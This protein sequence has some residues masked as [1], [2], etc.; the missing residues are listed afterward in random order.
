M[1]FPHAR[2]SV[3]YRGLRLV[4]LAA[5]AIT[6]TAQ[7][8]PTPG[9]CHG[10]CINL[11]DMSFI[12]DTS[13]TYYRFAGHHGIE[14]ATAPHLSGP[15]TNSNIP[16]FPNW[17]DD[18]V[19]L[20]PQI[21]DL[22]APDVHMINGTYYMFF[23][24]ENFGTAMYGYGDAASARYGDTAVATSSSLDG[25]TW[26]T[27]GL[28]DIPYQGSKYTRFDTSLLMDGDS[29]YLSFGSYSSGIFGM[30]M[31]SPPLQVLGQITTMLVADDFV[32]GSL[33]NRTEGS[34]LY[35][36]NGFYYIFYASGNC[37][38]GI[39]VTEGE[40]YK[41]E[42]CRSQSVSGP[43]HSRNGTSC[44]NGEGGTLLLPTHGEYV[45]APGSPSVLQDPV[46]GTVLIYQYMNPRIGLGQRHLIMGW[47]PLVFEDDWPTLKEVPPS[48]SSAAS[49]GFQISFRKGSFF[50]PFIKMFGLCLAT[51]SITSR[52]T[53]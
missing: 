47:N 38:T 45:Y 53:W 25:G 33:H 30:Q 28:L 19:H 12:R 5:V 29:L 44:L 3:H 48:P 32:P 6:A 24:V 34:F 10:Q 41:I 39:P 20:K 42:Y 46:Y 51:T 15:W 18:L 23:T 11:Q 1:Y 8:Y 17:A 16:A 52:Q 9:P 40:E 35:E 21:Q 2:V 4:L 49:S 50:R 22:W 7:L 27:H 31:Q 37:C 43:Y 36:N 26:H 13:G 14:I